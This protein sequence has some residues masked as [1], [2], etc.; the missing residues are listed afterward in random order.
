[1]SARN[2]AEPRCYA[3]R[4]G[5]AVT[6]PCHPTVLGTPDNFRSSL[7]ASEAAVAIAAG[8]TDAIPRAEVIT[9]PIAD[10][11]EG[12]LAACLS[13]GFHA[14]PVATI[15]P[16]GDSIT[17]CYARRDD[18]AV[19]ELAQASGVQLTGPSPHVAR[20]GS[21]EGTGVLIR[22]ALDSGARTVVLAVGGSATTD[23]G[24]GIAAALGARFLDD[25][26]ADVPPGADGLLQITRIDTT[27]L[28]PR[29]RGVDLVVATDVTAP[30]TGPHG[31]A[32]RFARQKG[33]TDDVLDFDEGLD[34]LACL[35]R[36]KTAV[37][38]AHVPGAGAAGGVAASAVTLL[39]ASIR[40][41][42]AFFLDLIGFDVQLSTSDIVITGEG[43]ID[44]QTLTGKGPAEVA[45]RAAALV[46]PVLLTVGRI[47]IT[48]AEACRL[49]IA[50][51]ASVSELEPDPR[52]QLQHTRTLLR[53]ATLCAI[54]RSTGHARSQ[55]PNRKAP[56]M[57]ASFARQP[58]Q[59]GYALAHAVNDHT[60]GGRR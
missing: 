9:Q 45:A 33:A 58:G 43:H 13:A 56:T 32:H 28:D 10:G 6:L 25:A 54:A 21:T 35:F 29:V 19:V 27:R 18:V 15:S 5:A 49:G 4:L 38:I 17:A 60:R 36:S 57:S 11:G 50:A 8:V 3:A 20:Y 51:M 37:D 46:K 24:T 22:D 16:S 55:L 31:A 26:G 23:G 47:S 7:T 30:L 12:S 39:G 34:H 14:V 41:S 53:H 40:R 48:T 52:R 1:M 59:C 42:A 44:A 2:I